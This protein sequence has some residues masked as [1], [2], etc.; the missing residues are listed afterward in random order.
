MDISSDGYTLLSNEQ[1]EDEPPINTGYGVVNDQDI[2][3]SQYET[4]DNLLEDEKTGDENDYEEPYWEPA[5]KEEELMAQLAV[6]NV[7]VI[8]AKDIEWVLYI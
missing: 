6:L 4:S 3:S 5:N 1:T 8:V 7:P 2:I